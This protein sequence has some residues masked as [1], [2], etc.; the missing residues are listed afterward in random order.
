VISVCVHGFDLFVDGGFETVCGFEGLVGEVMALEGFPFVFDVIQF[1]GI[2]G[3]PFRLEPMLT[4]GECITRGF[5]CMDRAVRSV[6]D[7]NIEFRSAGKSVI[8]RQERA[9]LLTE[10]TRTEIP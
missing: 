4:R 5:A 9:R 3:Q 1:R 10:R 7:V 6:Q 8:G 2:F